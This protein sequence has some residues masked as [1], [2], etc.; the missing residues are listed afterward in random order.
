M[1][2]RS[3]SFVDHI[4]TENE[5]EKQKSYQSVY[6]KT[7]FIEPTSDVTERLFS[8]CNVCFTDRRSRMTPNH[9]KEILLLQFK[10][11]MEYGTCSENCL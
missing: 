10:K 9:L 2:G 1:L 6:V 8:I 11:Y 7:E 5:D 4:M 3:Q